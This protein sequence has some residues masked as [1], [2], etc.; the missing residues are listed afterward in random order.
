MAHSTFSAK[1]KKIKG[2]GKNHT[3]NKKNINNKV[4]DRHSKH[5]FTVG[6]E[7]CE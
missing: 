3:N 7:Y 5:L 2:W 1:Q 6:I 4:D